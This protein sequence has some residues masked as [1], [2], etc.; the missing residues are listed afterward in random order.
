[1]TSI[2]IRN[3]ARPLAGPPA[4]EGASDRW[5]FAF[6]LGL[7]IFEL[8]LWF[9]GNTPLRMPLRIGAY[10]GSLA[11]L[12]LIRG[13]GTTHPA[14]RW[15]QIV[16]AI[17]LIQLL[18]PF[19]DRMLGRIAQVALYL[20]VLAP[21]IWAP[22]ARITQATF[23][24]IRKPMCHNSVIHICG[25]TGCIFALRLRRLPLPFFFRYLAVFPLP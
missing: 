12:V 17:L 21:L 14:H 15:I 1:M 25:F 5:V 16:I 24:G 20:A 8:A 9:L 6:T 3:S 10:G 11:C 13:H 22:R 18:N 19:G 4:N 7:F 23:Q 2:P